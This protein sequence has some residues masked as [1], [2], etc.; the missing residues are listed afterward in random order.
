MS[1]SD[2][3]VE[4]LVLNMLVFLIHLAFT[5]HCCGLDIQQ[6][7]REPLPKELCSVLIGLSHVWFIFLILYSVGTLSSV[8]TRI[9]FPEDPH[10]CGRSSVNVPFNASHF[11]K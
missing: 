10:T 4:D 2:V 9:C 1:E 6:H 7:S 5:G 8:P 11:F 3:L